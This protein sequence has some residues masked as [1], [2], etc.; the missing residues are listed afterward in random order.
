MVRGQSPDDGFQITKNVLNMSFKGMSGSVTIDQNGDRQPD[1]RYLLV[2]QHIAYIHVARIQ[3]NVW[4]H[5]QENAL[6]LTKQQYG[7]ILWQ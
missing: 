6:M 5:I 2:W 3:R 1:Q 7:F 4:R